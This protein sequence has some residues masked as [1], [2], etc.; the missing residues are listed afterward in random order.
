MFNSFLRL[1]VA[2]ACASL[3]LLSPLEA[4][5]ANDFVDAIQARGYLKVGLPPYNTPPAYFLEENSDELQGYDVDF[6]RTLAS[7]LGVEIQFDRSSK[8]FNNLVERVGNGDFDIAIGKLG[9]TYNR[10]FDAF[11][12]QYLSFRHAFL[13]NREFVASLGVDPDD[14]KFGEILKNSTIR[15]GS[16]KNSTWETE[17]KANFPN[18]TFVGFKNWPAAKKALFEKDS[19]ID[20]IYRDTT[21]IKPIVYS[22]P[23]LSLEYVPILFDELID[24]KSIYLSQDG[25]LGLKDFIDM[26]LRREWGGI[27]TDIN[28]LDEFQSFYLPS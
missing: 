5:A 3:L 17:A 6:A 11:P 26:A 2:F 23:D 1:I 15:I 18:A 13:A 22:Q 14:P 10:L 8:S 25:R 21:E 28:I 7:K 24:R 16:I 27:K 19:V 4:N 20:A 9:L 12:I